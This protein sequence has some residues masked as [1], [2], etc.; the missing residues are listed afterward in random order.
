M[1]QAMQNVLQSVHVSANPPT[2]SAHPSTERER[3]LVSAWKLLGVPYQYGAKGPDKLD[4]S[5]FAKAAY[6]G[7]GIDLPDGSFN[8]ATGERPLTS[9]AVLAPGDLLLYRWTGH[10]SVSPGGPVGGRGGTAIWPPSKSVKYIRG[11]LAYLRVLIHECLK[12][13]L[14]GSVAYLEYRVRSGH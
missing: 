12:E 3:L 5:G 4:C 14:N 6:E 9:I 13:R 10:G 7:I 2:P 11:S 1:R 8:Q